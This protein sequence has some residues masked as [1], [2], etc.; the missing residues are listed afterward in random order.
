M[1]PSVMSLVLGVESFFRGVACLVI[2]DIVLLFRLVF[3]FLLISFRTPSPLLAW[4]LEVDPLGAFHLGLSQPYLYLRI[5]FALRGEV[6]IA[7]LFA[8]GFF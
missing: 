6:R 3:F 8:F 4:A 2:N 7:F 1:G 5:L